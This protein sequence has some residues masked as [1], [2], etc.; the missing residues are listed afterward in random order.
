MH[1]RDKIENGEAIQPQNNNK[2]LKNLKV[3]RHYV[4]KFLQEN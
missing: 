4:R 1:P 3:T 2:Y